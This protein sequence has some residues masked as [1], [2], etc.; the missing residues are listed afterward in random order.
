MQ[1]MFAY[2]SVGDLWALAI[3][4]AVTAILAANCAIQKGRAMALERV[5]VPTAAAKAATAGDGVVA[6]AKAA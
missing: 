5:T 3:I 2:V 6:H 4:A 1:A